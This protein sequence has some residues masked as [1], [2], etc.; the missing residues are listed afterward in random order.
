MYAFQAKYLT[1]LLKSK[2]LCFIWSSTAAWVAA[3]T[4]LK[5]RLLVLP[6]SFLYADV[7]AKRKAEAMHMRLTIQKIF[8]KKYAPE[9]LERAYR[10]M[11]AGR[12]AQKREVHWQSVALTQTKHS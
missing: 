4:Q 10:Q 7:A 1:I 3:N 11:I 12:E 8:R 6:M 9:K 5:H 2:V